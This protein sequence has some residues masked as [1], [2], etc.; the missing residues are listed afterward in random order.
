MAELASHRQKSPLE[1]NS[2]YERSVQSLGINSNSVARR[3]LPGRGE[4]DATS[5]TG[6]SAK[7]TNIAKRRCRAAVI[8]RTH[9]M[10]EIDCWPWV[11]LAAAEQR[12]RA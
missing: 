3:R 1:S 7:A 5:I 2:W 12:N 4:M 6:H 9:L 11:G 8:V 10:P